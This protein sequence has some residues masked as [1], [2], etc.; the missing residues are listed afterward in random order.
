MPLPEQDEE[1]L[2]AHLKKGIEDRQW[3]ATVK[4]RLKSGEIELHEVLRQASDDQVI[5]KTRVLEI[6]E[7]MPQVG[8]VR[9]R[10]LME[11][12]DISPSR[13]LRGLGVNQRERLLAEFSNR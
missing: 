8:P 9:A 11:R 5:A 1:T 6:L 10:R 2:R 12:L 3:R 13:R 4:K 7:S